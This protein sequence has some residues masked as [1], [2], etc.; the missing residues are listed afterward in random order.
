MAVESEPPP[1]MHHNRIARRRPPR[2]RRNERPRGDPRRY[3]PTKIFGERFPGRRRGAYRRPV[4]FRAVA[5]SSKVAGTD[6]IRRSDIRLPYMKREMRFEEPHPGLQDSYRS[7]VRE[8]LERGEPLVPHA[9]ISP[10]RT[11]RRSWRSWRRAKGVKAC[12]PGSLRTRPIGWSATISSSAS[13]TSDIRSRMLFAARAGTSVT[14]FARAPGAKASPRNSYGGLSDVRAKSESRKRGLRA[15]R[16]TSR[17]SGRYC[18]T[19]DASCQ[20]SSCRSVTRS[21][22]D[23][24]F[25]CTGMSPELWITRAARRRNGR[26]R[27]RCRAQRTAS[28]LGV[29]CSKIKPFHL[30]F[31]FD[32]TETAMPIFPLTLHKTYLEKASSTSRSPSTSTSARPTAR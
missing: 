16:R 19:E 11:S 26:E 15:P 5:Q 10:T 28:H 8:F 12:R 25:L 32:G 14:A 31:D 30:F 13:L 21:C 9:L 7:L 23:T 2:Q 22:S 1:G 18:G 3:T 20:R 17:P 27:S 24:R 6:S 29:D 4:R